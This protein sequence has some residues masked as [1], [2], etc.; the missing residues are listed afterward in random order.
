[1]RVTATEGDPLTYNNRYVPSVSAWAFTAKVGETSDLIDSDDAYYLARLDSLSPG[2]KPT[3]ASMTSDIRTQLTLQKKLDLLALKAAQVS[4]AYAKGQPFDAAAK[5]AGLTVEH[6]PMFSRV[7]PVPGVGQAN[8]V[9]GAAFG[10]TIGAVSD[11][12]STQDAVY[13][14]KVD[15]HVDADRAAW[16]KQ[17]DQQRT[18]LLQRLRQQRVQ[19]FLADLRQNAKIEDHRKQIEQQNRQAA[20]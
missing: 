19:D 13:V 4:N 10:L 12:V 20:S 17:K 11:P 1:V 8:E 5:A 2:G 16:Q 6:T 18:Q 3:L 9:I 7:T 14:I 15:R